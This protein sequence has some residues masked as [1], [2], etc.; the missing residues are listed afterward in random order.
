MQAE[1]VALIEA[2]QWREASDARGKMLSLLQNAIGLATL[3][4]Y[5]KQRPYATDAVGTFVN[6]AEVKAALGARKD[7]VWEECSDAVI[8]A[9]HEDVMKSMKPGVAGS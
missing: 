1:A 2:A 4:D 7:L 6:R 3:Y 8:A 5:A 9:M